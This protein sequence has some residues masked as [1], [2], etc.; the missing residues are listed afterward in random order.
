MAE[1]KTSYRQKMVDFEDAPV[2]KTSTIKEDVLAVLIQQN[3]WLSAGEICLLLNRS[4]MP[5][6]DALNSLLDE[7]LARCTKINRVKVYEAS[8]WTL[9]KAENSIPKQAT[10]LGLRC[11]AR[12]R[13]KLPQS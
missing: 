13:I 7:K 5:V 9:Q 4:K 8:Q 1:L 10:T 3:R 12:Q 6:R 2:Q 11:S